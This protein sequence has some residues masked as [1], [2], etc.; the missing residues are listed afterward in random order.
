MVRQWQAELALTLQDNYVIGPPDRAVFFPDPSCYGPLSLN[1]S[2]VA[3]P[4]AE[5]L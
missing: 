3:P 5:F 1:L 4:P 2:C